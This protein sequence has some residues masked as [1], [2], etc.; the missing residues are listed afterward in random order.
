V[1]VPLTR[2][3]NSNAELMAELLERVE[4][5]ASRAAFV[6]GEEVD[7]FEREFA[8]YCD[9]RE[10]VGVSSGTTALA[11]ALQAV[12]VGQGDEVLVPANSFIATAEAVTL[13]GAIPR[14]VDVEPDS[15]LISA[16]T[17]EGALSPRTRAVIPVHLYGRTV[18]LG[19]ILALARRAGVAVIEDACQAHGARYKGRRVGAIGDCGCF[20]FYPTKNLGGWGDGGA[21]VT[22]DPAIAERV[23]LLRSHGEKPRYRHRVPGTTARL[24]TIQAAVLR[25]KLRRLD[26]W[27]GARRRLGGRL[28]EALCGSAVEL[29]PGPADGQDHVFHQYVVKT[30]D[31]DGLRAHLERYGVASAVHYPVPIHLT[32]A[33]AAPGAV[34]GS[35][36][37]TERLAHRICSLPIFP[38]MTPDELQRVGMAV[39]EFVP[40]A[41]LLAAAS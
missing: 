36:P 38:S 30:E 40:E 19:A 16:A 10:A 4:A 9:A 33:Y 5:V 26:D 32:E 21:V 23:R 8:A 27:N 1:T 35:L 12:G 41:A 7:A 20:S 22:N 34:P 6:Q 25:V 28:S 31:R 18:E 24:D 29:P 2:L 3:D 15:Q 14:F 11:L 37:V 17:V 13:A 39:A